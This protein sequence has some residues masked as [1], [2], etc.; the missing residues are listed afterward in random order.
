MDC[1]IHFWVYWEA[2][3]ATAIKVS[4]LSHYITSKYQRLIQLTIGPHSIYI[5]ARWDPDKKWLPLAYKVTNEELDALV[6][7]RLV[8]WRNPMSQEELSKE[9]LADAP[10]K[11]VQKE[12]SVH[13][14]NNESS[15]DPNAE[16]QCKWEETR[17]KWHLEYDAGS[18][19]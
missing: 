3:Q 11:P 5:Q 6:Q 14:Y 1:A 9:P 4:R 19:S 2:L 18:G 16:A 7:E 12:L 10:D 13:N 17:T 8:E 15:T